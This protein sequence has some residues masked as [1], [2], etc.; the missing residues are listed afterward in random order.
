MASAYPCARCTRD[1]CHRPCH[2]C[3]LFSANLRF[4]AQSGPS[5]GRR[6]QYKHRSFRSCALVLPQGA[7]ETRV[8]LNRHSSWLAKSTV[9][10]SLSH[11]LLAQTPGGFSPLRVTS[12]IERWPSCFPCRRRVRIDGMDVL[13]HA[14]GGNRPVGEEL[15]GSLPIRRNVLVPGR[16]RCAM[17]ACPKQTHPAGT[18]ERDTAL[19]ST[20]YRFR[21]SAHVRIRRSHCMARDTIREPTRGSA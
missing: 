3:T 13:R 14:S 4:G 21:P 11:A 18:G 1:R 15:L 7:D 20:A 5:Q 17:S 9:L 8:R 2:S 16:S 12:P 6:G 19:P 10:S